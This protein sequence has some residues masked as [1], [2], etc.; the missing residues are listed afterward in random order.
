MSLSLFDPVLFQHNLFCRQTVVNSASLSQNKVDFLQQFL[1]WEMEQHSDQLSK[2]LGEY[3]YFEQPILKHGGIS[4]GQRSLSCRRRAT[5]GGANVVH[6]TAY[7]YIII[8]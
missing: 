6:E 8:N 5:K 4:Q 7:S 1:P 3:L 2:N